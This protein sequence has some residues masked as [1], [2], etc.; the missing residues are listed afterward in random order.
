MPKITE[1]IQGVAELREKG[2]DDLAEA[3]IAIGQETL[4]RMDERFDINEFLPK[5]D[6]SEQQ[7]PEQMKAME[8][9]QKLQAIQIEQLQADLEETKSKTVKN[10]AQAEKFKEDADAE[11]MKESITSFKAQEESDR[12]DKQLRHE[13]HRDMMDAE[14]KFS[15]MQA[16]DRRDEREFKIKENQA[17]APVTTK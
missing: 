3:L 9:Q 1:L 14:M 15:D 6:P 10:L 8:E 13:Q 11:K 16:Q 17:S 4:R 12:S 2:E 7:T 5:K